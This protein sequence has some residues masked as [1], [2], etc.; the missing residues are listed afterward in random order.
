MFQTA[1][2]MAMTTIFSYPSY[3]YALPH[4]KYVLR[5]C[6]KCPRIDLPS[7]ESDHHNSNVSPRISFR[8]YQHIARCNV[9]GRR[10]F[11]E[12]K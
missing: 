3:N 12:N 2:Y 7:P 11:N 5:C 10:P 9:Y 6:E 1:S 8:V 4:W